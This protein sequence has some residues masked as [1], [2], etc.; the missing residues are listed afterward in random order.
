MNGFSDT[1]GSI[2]NNTTSSSSS[3]S[4]N[5]KPNIRNYNPV[6]SS[7]SKPFG[8]NYQPAQQQQQQQP[9]QTQQ[10]NDFR[11]LEDNIIRL[12]RGPDGTSGFLLKR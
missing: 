4:G 7:T 10:I 6:I 9:F 3:N 8:R 2:L 11:R 5:G 1:N 12:P